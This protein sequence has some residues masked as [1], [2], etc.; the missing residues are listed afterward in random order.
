MILL[1][2]ELRG[3]CP[4][5]YPQTESDVLNFSSRSNTGSSLKRLTES[6]GK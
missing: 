5:L 1:F 6:K 3:L 4:E 2:A